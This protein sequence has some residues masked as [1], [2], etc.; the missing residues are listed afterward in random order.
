MADGA[1]DTRSERF[2]TGRVFSRAFGT[3]AANPVAAVGIALLF[4]ALPSWG[5]DYAYDHLFPP[6]SS[7][8]LL[9]GKGLTQSIG[10]T[11]FATLAQG[12]FVRLTLAHEEGRRP[13][14]TEAGQTG[15]R[16]LLPLVGL[17]LVMSVATTIGLIMLVVPGV[18]MLLMWAVAAPVLVEERHGIRAALRGSAT[19]AEG[20]WGSILGISLIVVLVE[21]AAAYLLTRVLEGYY[22]ASAF[23]LV[24]R[25][26]FPVLY[27]SV[28]LVIDTITAT[29]SAAVYTSLYVEL[30]NFKHGTPKDALVEIFA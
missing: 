18:F 9:I 7:S 26:P 20:S 10:A 13:S 21:S 12:I 24:A 15:A 2:S 11:L 30:R 29:L 22:G 28:Q 14:F 23:L 17:G 1:P 3:F 27:L 19:L 4:G 16:A 6:G 25:E 8:A 5:Y